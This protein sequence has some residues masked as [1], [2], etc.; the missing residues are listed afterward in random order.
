MYLV[1]MC[2]YQYHQREV[3][4]DKLTSAQTSEYEVWNT[5]NYGETSFWFSDNLNFP[6]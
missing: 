1:Q 3:R 5:F 2:G 4:D 6:W